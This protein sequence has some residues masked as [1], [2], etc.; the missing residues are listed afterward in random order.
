MNPQINGKTIKLFLSLS[1]QEK[2]T[3]LPT[4]GKEGKNKKK[5]TN[6]KTTPKTKQ[7]KNVLSPPCCRN[8]AHT[9]N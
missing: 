7:T 6:K 4:L 1:I 2:P 3:K 8:Q 5:Q 9:W